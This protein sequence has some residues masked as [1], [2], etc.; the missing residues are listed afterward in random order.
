M[1]NEEKKE[2]DVHCEAWRRERR[3]EG[4]EMKECLQKV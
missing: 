1:K 3:E 4:M 2:C